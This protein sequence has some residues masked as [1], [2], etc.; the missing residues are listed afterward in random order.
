MSCLTTLTESVGQEGNSLL[1]S[2]R[3]VEISDDSSIAAAFLATKERMLFKEG[4]PCQIVPSSEQQLQGTI[5]ASIC[6][7]L[8]SSKDSDSNFLIFGTGYD[9]PFWVDSN[10]VAKTR[11]L[12][13][14]SEWIQF[15][16]QKV[17]DLVS[18][19]SYTSTMRDSLI[20][21]SDK[22][23]LN[24][25]YEN[26][27]PQDVKETHWKQILVDSPEGYDTGTVNDQGYPGRG[28]SIYAAMK[29]AS[30]DTVIYV[31]DCEREVEMAYIKKYLQ[32]GRTLTK[33]DNGHNVIPT[34]FKKANHGMTCKLEP[35][36]KQGKKSKK[37]KA[38]V[39][40]KNE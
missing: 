39:A 30:S 11:F 21:I 14:H 19:V 37:N 31:D 32:R 34:A 23:Y 27:V 36:S 3:V 7:Q 4:K 13:H 16:P 38:S 8:D 6:E 25:F 5:L 24:D 35:K 17:K 33:I 1:Q 29:L 9:S 10:P 2:S 12:E 28:Q 15:Q 22:S 40:S 26:Q 20:K 18:V